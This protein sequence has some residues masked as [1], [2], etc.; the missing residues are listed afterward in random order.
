MRRSFLLS[1][2]PG[3]MLPQ[4]IYKIK[5]PRSAKNA[6]PEISAWKNWIKLSQHVA[7]LLNLC[8]LKKLSAGFGEGQSPLAPFPR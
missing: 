8:V 5:G 3:D 1:G 7:L 6:F 4:K 2:G